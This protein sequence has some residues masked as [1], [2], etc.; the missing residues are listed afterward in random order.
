MDGRY[1]IQAQIESGKNFEI[2]NF[3]KIFNCKLFKDLT[4][5]I[6]PKVFTSNQI[7]KFFGK[8]NRIKIISENL[9]DQLT[10][11]KTD[12]NKQFFSLPDNISGMSYKRKISN[13]IKL[14][15]KKFCTIYLFQHPKMLLGCSIL[16]V[17][18]IQIVLYLTV[19]FF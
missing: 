6:D 14:L 13:L 4:I 8:S 19:K 18:I 3:E 5:G 9:I 15:K 2:V 7:K 10:K 16:E 12:N 1:T 17:M 11:P